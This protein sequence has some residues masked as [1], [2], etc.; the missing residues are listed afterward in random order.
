MIQRNLSRNIL[1]NNFMKNKNI[2]SKKDMNMRAQTQM[3]TG[4]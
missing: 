3:K 1:L 4:Q 2:L